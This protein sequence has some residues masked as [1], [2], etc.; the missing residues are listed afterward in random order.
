MYTEL[1]PSLKE[2]EA[3]GHFIG[4][5]GVPGVFSGGSQHACRDQVGSFSRC[6]QVASPQLG[7]RM[8]QRC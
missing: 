6:R 7:T 1:I 3:I 4:M 2:M 5:V 8:K